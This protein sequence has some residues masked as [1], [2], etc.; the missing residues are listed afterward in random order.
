MIMELQE[1]CPGVQYYSKEQ[2]CKLCHISKATALY[3][4]QSGLVPVIDTGKPT[5]RYWISD[6]DVKQYLKA[7]RK[8]PVKFKYQFAPDKTHNPYRVGE[9]KHLA[10]VLR[11]QWQHEAELL[12]TQEV[13][14]LLGY[15]VETVQCW[16]KSGALFHFRSGGKQYIPKAKLLLFISTPFFHDIH[17][18]SSLHIELLRRL[19][20]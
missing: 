4:I 9:A 19:S 12:T 13:A 3:L 1:K 17:P 6:T 5:C 14:V 15:R 18:K 20:T 8:D 16:C 11:K 2:F 7:R 10:S